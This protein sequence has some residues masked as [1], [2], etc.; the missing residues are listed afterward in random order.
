M[1]ARQFVAST[2]NVGQT[3][4]DAIGREQLPAAFLKKLDNFQHTKWTI[5]GLHL[6]LHEPVR[7]HAEKFDPNIHRTLKWSLGA[8]TME[9]LL[10]AHQDVMANRVPEI[11]QFGSGP[12]S[13]I[14]PTQAPPGKHTTYAWHVM[15]FAPDHGCKDYETF[16]AGV[17]RARS[18]RSG[19]STRRT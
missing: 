4:E 15:P 18:S 16:K 3:F 6:A 1:R 14:D 10:A 5:F 17:R 19:R 12:L 7:F 9:E 11:V 2:L 13:V 8:E